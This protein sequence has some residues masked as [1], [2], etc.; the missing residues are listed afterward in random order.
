MIFCLPIN[1]YLHLSL[2]FFLILNFTSQKSIERKENNKKTKPKTNQNYKYCKG[3]LKTFQK[4]K[5]TNWKNLLNT[6]KGLQITQ[7]FPTYILII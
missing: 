7:I 3:F 1:K 2:L 5:K 6:Q 4:R